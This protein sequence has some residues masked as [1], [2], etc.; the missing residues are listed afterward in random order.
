MQLTCT[1]HNGGVVKETSG[2]KQLVPLSHIHIALKQHFQKVA[3]FRKYIP[4]HQ[5]QNFN[6]LSQ[7]LQ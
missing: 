5:I 4:Q 1:R 2:N 7:G 6:N 3:M